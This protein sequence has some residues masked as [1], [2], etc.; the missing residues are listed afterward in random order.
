MA[1]R[2]EH[3]G[4]DN[5]VEGYPCLRCNRLPTGKFPKKPHQKRPR[6]FA[7][8]LVSLVTAGVAA[9]GLAYVIVLHQGQGS[10]TKGSCAQSGTP[11]Q[12]APPISYAVAPPPD[13]FVQDNSTTMSLA[14]LASEFTN[15]V[16]ESGPQQRDLFR[17]TTDLT[18]DHFKYAASLTAHD[19]TD[20]LK[21]ILIEFP[22][23]VCSLHYSDSLKGQLGDAAKRLH[24]EKLVVS[25][26]GGSRAFTFNGDGNNNLTR[27]VF[28]KGSY[29]AFVESNNLEVAK[30]MA[31]SQ[32]A[33]LPDV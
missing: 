14:D 20:S 30:T 23:S 8:Q 4:Q 32:A 12:G 24:G 28:V 7:K 31:T 9:V 5:I 17:A 27:I 13:G 1:W 21:S 11:L 29:V 2:C 3:C 19:T 26:P 22:S 33:Y 18:N 15:S 25:Q 16:E 6:R 10:P